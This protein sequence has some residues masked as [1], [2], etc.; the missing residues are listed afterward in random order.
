[1]AFYYQEQGRLVAHGLQI[2]ANRNDTVGEFDF[3]LESGPDAL[4]HIEFATKFYL[5]QGEAGQEFDTPW[6]GPTWPTAWARRCA[7]FSGASWNWARIPPP[8]LCCRAR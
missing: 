6:S 2:R 5:L 3:L 4:E 8:S 7:R 1:M